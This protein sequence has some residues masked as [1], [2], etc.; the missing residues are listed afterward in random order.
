MWFW[1]PR[2]HWRPVS[3][4]VS[5]PTPTGPLSVT[6][7]ATPDRLEFDPGD[8]SATRTCRGPGR[9]W[10]TA[11]GDRTRSTCMHTYLRA[12]HRTATGAYL[13]R[14]TTVWKVTWRT[15]RGV[16]G[17][18]PDLRTH[19]TASITVREIQAVGRR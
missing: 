14:L 8:G 11:L 5:V 19:S 7:T 16:S 10:T 4:T 15:N 2:R 18:A 6:T 13:A 9:A 3:V 17:R 1:V 12:S